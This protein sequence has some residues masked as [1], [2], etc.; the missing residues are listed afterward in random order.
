MT[1]LSRRRVLAL[2]GAAGVARA[3]PA[4]AAPDHS[5]GAP[6]LRAAPARV[7]LTEAGPATAVWAFDG[8]APGP[9]LRGALGDRLDLPVENAT[10]RPLSIRVFGLRGQTA[11]VAIP[12]GGRG[13]LRAAPPD[14]GT[15]WYAAE[16][17]LDDPRARGL[18]G[19]F[20]VEEPDAH[21]FDADR[22]LAVVLDAWPVAA[23]GRL[24]GGPVAATLLA[25][26]RA[27]LAEPAHPGERL[28]LRVINAAPDRRFRL[29]LHGWTGWIV[30]LDGNPLIAVET[31]AALDLWPGQRADVVVDAPVEFGATAALV[32]V[33]GPAPR[34][35][36]LFVA[37]G[38]PLDPLGYAPAPLA[39]WAGLAQ[40]D[41]AP[42]SRAGPE[43]FAPG[44][45]PVTVARGDVLG[46][47]L[48][49]MPGD[50][51]LSAEGALV[52]RRDGAA[53]GPWRDVLGVPAGEAA[54]VAIL[55]GETGDWVIERRALDGGA[56]RRAALRVGSRLPL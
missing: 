20:I 10:P 21:A 45:P 4:S 22:D 49:P 47:A 29:A 42:A 31:M 40:D 41:V 15:F 16:D 37:D 43:A 50:T 9:E 6:P 34:T 17:R 35:L 55:A 2:A 36:A 33:S 23:D 30:A 46:L 5:A 26:G 13:V 1:G 7:A 12:A 28:R 18:A 53:P 11:R 38:E 48:A 54:D 52:R 44:A 32:D 14:P 19:A 25:N 51:V 3:V 24:T 27:D 8:V 56:P 39:P